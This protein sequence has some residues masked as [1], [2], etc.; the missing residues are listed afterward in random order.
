MAGK[1]IAFKP[2]LKGESK[3]YE[4]RVY[5]D[6][7][8]PIDLSI[9]AIEFQVNAPIGS[10]Y[11]PLIAKS[12]VYFP[13]FNAQLNPLEQSVTPGGTFGAVFFVAASGPVNIQ[14]S[15]VSATGN[16]SAKYGQTISVPDLE[17]PP[18]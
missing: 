14:Y 9:A 3:T 15:Y 5:D 17:T 13:D 6:A 1:I 2:V 12:R 18:R 16:E 10:P 8:K 7:N 4:F 11:N